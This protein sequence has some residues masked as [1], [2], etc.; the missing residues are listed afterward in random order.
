M[1]CD[2]IL[3]KG[4]ENIREGVPDDFLLASIL[5]CVIDNGLIVDHRLS[6]S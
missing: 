2:E 4:S 1:R 6:H 3:G 5:T